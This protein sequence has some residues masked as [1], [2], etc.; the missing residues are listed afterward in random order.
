[1]AYQCHPE[2]SLDEDVEHDTCQSTDGEAD[3]GSDESSEHCCPIRLRYQHD[4]DAYEQTYEC[5]R[6]SGEHVGQGMATRVAGPLGM[7]LNN[8]QVN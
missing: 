4:T 7:P 3:P 2:A 5:H 6:E 1:M 8:R